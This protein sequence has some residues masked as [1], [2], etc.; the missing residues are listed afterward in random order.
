MKRS[1]ILAL[2]SEMKRG[3]SYLLWVNKKL[4]RLERNFSNVSVGNGSDSGGGTM[5]VRC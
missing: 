1:T 2:V 3:E 5:V 4:K